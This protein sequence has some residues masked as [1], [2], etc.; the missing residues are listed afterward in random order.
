[1]CSYTGIETVLFHK[2]AWTRE[3]PFYLDFHITSTNL[4]VYQKST[5]YMGQKIFNSLPSYIKEEI[6]NVR[7]F[8]WLLNNFLYCKNFYTLDEYF[9][10]K[11]G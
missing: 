3:I 9:D 5:Y 4:A 2:Y 10:Y 1:M 6:H 11:E 7:K 8:R